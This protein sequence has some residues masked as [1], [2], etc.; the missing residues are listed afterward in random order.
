M[1]AQFDAEA[2]AEDVHKKEQAVREAA[3]YVAKMQEHVKS[4]LDTHK[5]KLDALEEVQR[6]GRYLK[7]ETMHAVLRARIGLDSQIYYVLTAS[8]QTPEEICEQLNYTYMP[9]SPLSHYTPRTIEKVLEEWTKDR[10]RHPKGVGDPDAHRRT[11][12]VSAHGRVPT[13]PG[14]TRVPL[15]GDSAPRA[16]GPCAEPFG[17]V[18]TVSL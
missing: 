10:A 1:D 17:R 12:S 4:A 18:A 8:E 9:Q 13:H 11:N 5:L 14:N 6:V 2:W 7:E 16:S 15:S 3:R